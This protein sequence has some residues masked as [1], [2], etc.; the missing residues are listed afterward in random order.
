MIKNL[1]KHLTLI[2]LV[3]TL[4]IVPISCNNDSEEIKTAGELVSS[5]LL[6]SRTAS[7]TE[8]RL[9]SFA[10]FLPDG[11]IE[12]IKYDVELWKVEYLTTYK[13]RQVTASGL[14]LVPI[15]EEGTDVPF[16][17]FQH[18]T[19]ASDA[20]APTNLGTSDLQLALLFALSSSGYMTVVPDFIGFGSSG[21]IVH[22]Y[23]VEQPSSDAVIDNLSAVKELADANG[24]EVNSRL[25]LAGYSQGGY[26]TMAAHKAFEEREI[27]FFDLQ[28]SFPSSG[29]YYIEGVRDFFF[30]QETYHQ[31]F[32][33]AYVAEAYRT[34]YDKEQSFLS[35]LFQ[36][37]FAAKIPG[38]FDGS[39]SGSQINNQLTTTIADLVNADY[40]ENTN[41]SQ[42]DELNVLFEENS[43]TNWTP[44]IPLFMYHGDADITVPY[45]NSIDS[46]NQFIEGGASE[47][48]VTFTTLPGGTHTSGFL[49]YLDELNKRLA[50]FEN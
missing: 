30:A 34:Y 42:F 14:V 5:E 29:G 45:Q 23:Y 39:Q 33:M 43:L 28:A 4:G 16:M 19:I 21:D 3:I 41:S 48:I 20:E 50:E 2:L 49:I 27:P 22:P 46:Y 6:F 10:A 17:S 11:I 24:V 36:Q 44:T 37:E 32:F 15:V 18:G 40:L 9:T 8:T 25:Y 38:L 26:V 7:N 13:D 47:S 31:P 12:T 1:S 35:L